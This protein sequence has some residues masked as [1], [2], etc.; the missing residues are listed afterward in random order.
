MPVKYMGR[1]KKWRNDHPIKRQKIFH[2]I[3]W[4]MYPGGS[5]IQASVHSQCVGLCMELL[6]KEI[7]LCDEIEAFE[8]TLNKDSSFRQ[9]CK[10]VYSC[11]L[12]WRIIVKRPGMLSA[13]FMM[14]HKPCKPKPM[15]KI[16]C[17][18]TEITVIEKL[19][20]ASAKKT[21]HI[22]MA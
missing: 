10:W 15:E 1:K 5:K 4:N 22:W 17:C 8:R 9:I 21:L 16:N 2:E 6:P 11:N 12:I 14:L 3:Q 18:L 13:Q 7:R 19:H 20:S